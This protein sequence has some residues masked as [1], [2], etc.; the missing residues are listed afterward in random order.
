[1]SGIVLLILRA[2]LTISLYCFLGWALWLMWRSL[3]QGQQILTT[4]QAASLGLNVQLGDETQL[5]QFTSTEIIIG[6]DPNCACVIDSKTVSA[7]H[8]R[9]SHY[10]G[11]WWL[12]DLNS[13]N[14]TF[15]NQ[16][17]VT[18]PTVLTPGDQLRCGEVKLSV[19]K[20]EKS[21][22]SEYN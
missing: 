6:R 12:E 13:T 2:A 20:Y 22:G 9:L 14:G 5:R 11:Q 7:H 19:E 4:R 1:M 3:K 15:L 10:Q 21:L 16:E 17:S 18:I 8:A